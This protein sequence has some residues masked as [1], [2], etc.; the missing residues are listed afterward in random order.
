MNIS[1]ELSNPEADKLRQ[2]SLLEFHACEASATGAIQR[3]EICSG[4]SNFSA[5]NYAFSSDNVEFSACNSSFS[6]DA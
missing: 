5:C 3:P 1:F 2:I 4:E 6:K